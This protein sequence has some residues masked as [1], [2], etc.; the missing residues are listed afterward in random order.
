VSI[1]T[2]QLLSSSIFSL[3][4][5]LY[6]IIHR[7]RVECESIKRVNGG[8]S[9]EEEEEEGRKV[10]SAHHRNFLIALIVLT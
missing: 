5:S 9:W 6:F 10:I 1:C 4:H 7:S 3:I 8:V 2:Q